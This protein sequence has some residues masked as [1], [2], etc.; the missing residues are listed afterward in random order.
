MLV[1]GLSRRPVI[2]VL[3]AD[4]AGDGRFA[5]GVDAVAIE[6]YFDAPAAD[7]ASQLAAVDAL[8]RRALATFAPLPLY[9]VVQAYDKS[10]GP[11]PLAGVWEARPDLLEAIQA[12]ANDALAYDRVLGLWWFAYARPGGV[13]T[14][15]KLEAWHAAQVA[16]TP[17]PVLIAP[18]TPPVPPKKPETP[19]PDT[20]TLADIDRTLGDD[21]PEDL[22]LGALKRFRDE[23]CLER[24]RV[25]SPSND[26]VT[27]GALL[28]FARG[29]SR[30]RNRAR[31][32]GMSQVDA[33]VAGFLGAAAD[34][35]RAVGIVVTQERSAFSGPLGVAGKDFVVPG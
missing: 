13:R 15:P 8:V 6:L 20:F 21:V 25:A 17:P 18:P 28:F 34:Y 2:A 24:D 11:G 10:D 30:E 12:G 35:K 3:T 16:V 9:L 27:G 22:F 1:R 31:F 33:A 26:S 23:V 14:Y 4:K 29:F 7:W 5:T 32:R 19:M